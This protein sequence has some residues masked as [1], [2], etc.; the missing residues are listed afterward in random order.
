MGRVNEYR[1]LLRTLESWDTFLL[2]ESRL[3]G[4]RANLELAFAVAEE[5][6]DELFLRYAA[7]DPVAAQTNTQEE[8]LAVCGVIGLGFCAA[9]GEGYHLDILR[10]CASDPRWRIREAVALGL[11]RFGQVAFD[12]LMVEMQ[13]WSEG[14]TLER[15][16][17][18]AT[19][20]EPVLLSDRSRAEKVIEILDQISASLINESDRRSE[21]FKV[22]RK[23]LGY[24]WSVVVAS[25]PD[26]GKPAMEVW[27]H[28]PDPDIRW[29][30]KQNLRK[31]RL[32]RM[33]ETWVQAQWEALGD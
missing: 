27:I 30:I 4:P 12:D 28:N 26:I 29:V 16:A 33:D 3:P 17:I 18:V 15:R 20:C 8:F 23:G 10:K 1:N 5:G 14:N 9:R 25:H 19:L 21:E 11:Q 13:N 6:G 22:L 2:Q 7:L 24:G 32:I 31:N